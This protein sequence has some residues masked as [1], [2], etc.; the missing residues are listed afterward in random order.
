MTP[1]ASAAR[2][3]GPPPAHLVPLGFDAVTACV[4]EHDGQRMR[5]THR[6]GVTRVGMA[7]RH[8]SIDMPTIDGH[9]VGGEYASV[10]LVEVMASNGRYR[11]VLPRPGA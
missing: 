7:A 10:V 8:K 6:N 11:Q 1:R 3:G 2:F 9:L 5:F 4:L